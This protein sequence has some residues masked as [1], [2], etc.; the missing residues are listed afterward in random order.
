MRKIRNNHGATKA[1]SGRHRSD[2]LR[3]ASKTAE[4]RRREEARE[5]KLRSENAE[6]LADEI[7]E[8]AGRGNTT[9]GEAPSR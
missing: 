1:K 5:E 4:A 3:K 6:R 8:E 9:F 2:R 7:D